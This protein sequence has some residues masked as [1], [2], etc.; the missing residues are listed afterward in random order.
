MKFKHPHFDPSSGHLFRGSRQTLGLLLL[1]LSLLPFT[2]CATQPSKTGLDFLVREGRLEQTAMAKGSANNLIFGGR[3]ID[4]KFLSVE[5]DVITER[6]RV[7]RGDREASY[8]VKLTP[9]SEGRTQ[10]Q[11]TSP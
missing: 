10:I 6:W 9:L 8:I 5:G 3:V 1:T 7:K 11:V 4:T 2:G